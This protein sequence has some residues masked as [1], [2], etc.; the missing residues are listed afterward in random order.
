MF[1]WTSILTVALALLGMP[2]AQA[3]LADMDKGPYT[4]A[5]GYF[6]R[7]YQDTVDPDT[8]KRLQL[9]LS[10]ATND[11]G[12]FMCTLLPNP[13]VFDETQPLAFPSNFPDESFWMLAEAEIPLTN[14]MELEVFVAGIE[15]AF[16]GGVPR[17][18][19]QQS[20]ARIRIRATVPVAGTYIVTH[21]Y[22]VETFKVTRAGR[23]AINMTRDIGIGAAGDFSGALKGD[24]GPFLQSTHNPPYT[25]TNPETGK[26]ETF[27][28]D[29]SVF[30]TVTG[31]PYGTNFVRIDGP[32]GRTIQTDL[33]SLSG[34]L[35]NQQPPTPL[36]I[37][38]ATY[39]RDNQDNKEG[40]LSVFA[41]SSS[42]A[43][44]CYRESIEL[45]GEP[46]SPCEQDLNLVDTQHGLFQRHGTLA[47]A[48]DELPP[49]YLIFT[50]AEDITATSAAT[51]TE[52]TPTTLSQP[53]TDLVT[54]TMAHFSWPSRS[55]TIEARS[56][57]EVNMPSMVADGFGILQQSGSGAVQTLV[58]TGLQLP[59]ASVTVKSAAGGRDTRLV[60]VEGEPE[61]PANQAPIAYPDSA[62]TTGGVTISLT[63]TA[64]DSDPEG[65]PVEIASID[66]GSNSALLV[67]ES[68]SSVRFTAPLVTAETQFF[69][70]YRVRDSQGNLSEPA[71]ITV[72][73]NPNRAPVA[74]NDPGLVT[75]ADALLTINVLANDVDPDG[76]AI[77]VANTTQPAQGSVAI[78]PDAAAILYTPPS[79][80]DTAVTTTF[81]YQAQDL[82]GALSDPATVTVT[83][84]P[85]V[86]PDNLTISKA[87]VKVGSNNRYSWDIQGTT[88]RPQNNQITI[89]L[90]DSGIVLGSGIAPTANGRWRL[91]VTNNTAPTGDSPSITV[92]SSYS[93]IATRSLTVR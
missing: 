79:S 43:T 13:G 2:M 36:Q 71:S 89:T 34:M 4:A 67:Q 92:K 63:L 86:G 45:T 7:W 80:V 88:S 5:T 25:A 47:L 84:N 72:T 68:N 53:L 66:N 87:E 51:G 85:R 16:A 60:T 82:F 17:Q 56:S 40:R 73:V 64:N 11:R 22:G 75:T 50:A 65:D 38:R 32:N 90:T 18:G 48:P 42:T 28:G 61:R 76:N 59:P 78:T 57:D 23:R 30:E 58:A 26:L 20:F 33:F 9:C 70:S 69:F 24:I 52:A 44:V 10:K 41:H 35:D 14:G 12:S 91:S 74:A 6:P 19:E 77:T 3:Q 54:I 31:S 15:A 1:N 83:V 8:S 39:S 37:E 62:S 55:L 21:P 81:T 46:P 29:P 27:I 49:P 93:G